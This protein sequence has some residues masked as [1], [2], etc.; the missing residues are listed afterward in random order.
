MQLEFDE[1]DVLQDAV[2]DRLRRILMLCQQNALNDFTKSMRVDMGVDRKWE[3]LDYERAF[4][5]TLYVEAMG[6]IPPAR[7]YDQV[8][9]GRGGG[10]EA[11][12]AKRSEKN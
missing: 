12:E 7:A 11:N 5:K 2:D 6:H 1:V 4:R 8:R 9:V 3:L 10:G